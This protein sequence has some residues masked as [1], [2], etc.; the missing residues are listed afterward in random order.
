MILCLAAGIAQKNHLTN[1]NNGIIV[2]PVVKVYTAPNS[3]ENTSFELHEG[4]KFNILKTE[5]NWINIS[6][7]KNSGWVE[8]E[9]VLL[10]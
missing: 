9:D 8:K 10:Y 3:E 6:L 4:A 1:V 5:G 2:N 7:N